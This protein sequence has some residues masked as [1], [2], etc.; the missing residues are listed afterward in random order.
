MKRLIVVILL[1]AFLLGGCL[2]SP[3]DTTSTTSHTLLT[4]Q[5]SAVQFAVYPENTDFKV[6]KPF[7]RSDY[8]LLNGTQKQIYIR[9][10]NAIFLMTAGYIGL[11]SCTETDIEIAY[12]A[13]RNDRPEYFWVPST[14]YLRTVGESNEVCFAK[15]QSDWLYTATERAEIE[16]KIKQVLGEAFATLNS[17][18]SQYEIELYL[19]DWLLDRVSYDKAALSNSADHRYAWGIDGAFSKGKAVCEGYAKAMQLLMF[20][21]GIECGIVLGETDKAHAWN[22]VKIGGHWYHLD[23]THN[24]SE[25]EINHFFFNVTTENILC[26]RKIDPVLATATEDEL[27]DGRYNLF[28][29]Y[30]T[31]EDMNYHI[32]NSLYI[33]TLEQVESTV[34][35]QICNAVRNGQRSVEFSVS[36]D[37]GFVFGETDAAEFFKLQRCVSAANAELTR[38]QQ[39]R[40]F[41]Y[42][43]VEGALGFMISW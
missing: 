21:A 20:T 10:D 32:E 33:G 29:P 4:E 34:V 1:C 18:M 39:I 36:K 43:G 27:H 17:D 23:P 7:E 42:G 19:H 22:V 11:G 38:K 25:D 5:D 3:Q 13:L 37:L 16:G 40:S 41:T 8:N 35:S 6:P 26:S 9:L 14:Y 24:D 28:L 15:T 2:G 12:R 31:A 30:A